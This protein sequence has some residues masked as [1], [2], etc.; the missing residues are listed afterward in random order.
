MLQG[1]GLQTVESQAF[2][3][4]APDV[5]VEIKSKID[6]SMA[7]LS[8]VSCPPSLA[9]PG[10]TEDEQNGH[11]VR[12]VEYLRDKDRYRVASL[13]W[14]RLDVHSRPSWRSQPKNSSAKTYAW[15]QRLG[16]GYNEL[17]LLHIG[18]SADAQLVTVIDIWQKTGRMKFDH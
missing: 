12:I 13:T 3:F 6:V 9:P 18:K 10:N 2:W 17:F 15:R 4:S 8:Q 7:H 5:V 14:K 1:L 11:M 16:T